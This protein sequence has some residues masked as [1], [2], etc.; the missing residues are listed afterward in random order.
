ML[1][2]D[3]SIAAEIKKVFFAYFIVLSHPSSSPT[4]RISQSLKRKKLKK[5]KKRTVFIADCDR[6]QTCRHTCTPP[7]CW[8]LG[9]HPSKKLS[10]LLLCLFVPRTWTKWDTVSLF[11][12][13]RQ[14]ILC[15]KD[16]KTR[17]SFD[18]FIFSSLFAG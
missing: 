6:N 11:L 15:R 1:Y 16:R 5:E 13:G 12:G 7:I 14:K 4:N 9:Y 3:Q 8:S 18:C 17:A 2:T 10:L